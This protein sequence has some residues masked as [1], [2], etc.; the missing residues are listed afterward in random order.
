MFRDT[1]PLPEPIGSKTRL[2]PSKDPAS[3]CVR[4][5]GACAAWAVAAGL[6]AK[7]SWRFEASEFKA[8]PRKLSGAMA[9]QR[10]GAK[11]S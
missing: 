7:A 6:G 5:H 8:D 3:L 10:L 11:A 2:T 9:P 4:D 1:E